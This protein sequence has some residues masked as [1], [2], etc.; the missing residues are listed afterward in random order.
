MDELNNLN[1][2]NYLKMK[3]DIKGNISFMW[4]DK[5]LL[6]TL[7]KKFEIIYPH[8]NDPTELKEDKN[9]IEINK[10]ISDFN[11]KKIIEKVFLRNIDNRLKIILKKYPEIKYRSEYD[12]NY[13]KNELSIANR[14]LII[15]EAGI[16]KS[17]YLYEFSE[18]LKI[19]NIPYLCI[20]GKYTKNISSNV[21][22]YIC[23][24]DSEFYLIIDA[25]NE[26]STKEQKLMLKFLNNVKNNFNIN[27]IVSYRIRNLS[28]EIEKELKSILNNLYK[29][30]G[31]DYEDS[32]EKLIE[33]YGIEFNKY[34][35]ILETNNPAYLRMLYTIFDYNLKKNKRN[36]KKYVDNRIGDL[37]Q[38][39]SILEKY[40]KIICGEKY[41]GLTKKICSYMYNNN[42]DYITY[43]EIKNV[44]LDQIDSYLEKMSKE[45]LIDSYLYDGQKNYVF[46]MQ[47][48][49]DYLIVRSLNSEIDNKTIGEIINIVNNKI[50][51]KNSWIEPIII[52]IFDK[53]KN[54]DITIAL[55]IISNSKLKEHFNFEI[56]RK[57]IFNKK[58]IDIF[59]T[60]MNFTE[61]A[62]GILQLG[63]FHDRPY[64]CVNYYNKI[65]LEDKSK[66]KNLSFGYSFSTSLF[67]LKN[68]LYNLIL[69]NKSNSYVEEM[70]WYSFWLSSSCIDRIRNLC[71]KV[72]YE[73]CLKFP[74]YCEKLLELYSKVDEYY[75]KKTIIHVLT[76][77]N[78]INENNIY[79][80]EQIYNDYEEIDYE[81]IW[82]LFNTKKFKQ[83]Y[84][85]LSKKN[86]YT[87]VDGKYPVDKK[88]DMKHILMIAD[89]YEKYLL[90]FERY[91]Y[92]DVINIHE[93]L[94]LNDK[95]EIIKWNNEFKNRFKCISENGYCEYHLYDSNFKKVMLPINY[96]NYSEKTM[97][98]MYQEIFKGVCNYYNYI[99]DKTEKFDEHL[100]PFSN[101][102]LRK[103]L[104][105]SQDLMYGSLMC[106]YYTSKISKIG[107]DMFEPFTMDERYINICTPVSLYCEDVQN[108]NNKIEKK[109]DLNGIRDNKWYNDNM[110]PIDNL[111]SLLT[112]ISYGGNEWIPIC[113]NI[114]KY[115]SD[116]KYN[117]LYT[118]SYDWTI[119][120]DSSKKLIGDSNSG[121]LTIERENF[122]GNI[123][124][125][126]EYSYTKSVDIETIEYNSNDF[127]NT[128]LSFPPPA[129]IKELKLHYDT[130]NSTW[131][132]SRGDIVLY[133]DNNN[134]DFFSNPITNDIYM[135]KD[136]FDII[137]EKFMVLFWAYTEKNYLN[138]GWNEEASL[139]LEFDSKGNIISKYKNNSLKH[140]EESFNNKC[141][142]CKYG[143]F[144]KLNKPNSYPKI[145][146]I[147]DD[148]IKDDEEKNTK[149]ML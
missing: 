61:D 45:N 13:Y 63:G 115:V 127:K 98:I 51:A 62:S 58:Q 42:R 33:F 21:M 36:K 93:E 9:F 136:Y 146:L 16:G 122:E 106:N 3:N 77:I 75:L 25:F 53:Y 132:N 20:Y 89:I 96:I 59:Q 90:N 113:I 56:I 24:I 34:F 31:V 18:K 78:N 67:K 29:F 120:V 52:L 8:Y 97:F 138:K 19:K 6:N 43:Q 5:Y 50:N 2:E 134:S 1:Y 39:T 86:V 116:D 57:M 111:K 54:D 131:K 112:P 91:H 44:I 76:S 26:L 37:V 119:S 125:F 73:I 102:I 83:S 32:L 65:L 12:I 140:V 27:I 104:L 114:H 46:T 70:F 55:N 82:R 135:R 147:I 81:I 22:K 47:L 130:K 126:I 110:L 144:Q 66:I 123:L 107:Y 80:F 133:C 15:G 10:Y 142:K 118:E 41:W 143:I 92:D 141:K 7:L 139:H 137:C 72:L 11:D 48:M 121:E 35:D 74:E 145:N 28:D 99:Y 94:I 108:L 149:N 64:N 14:L 68:T 100:N 129:I 23:K 124:K 38:I 69:I 17:Y 109:F 60:R 40:I 49:S 95:N 105:I 30:E 101:S 84:I 88:L 103:C 87:T 85:E 148:L 128:N 79:K 117:H 4:K 71:L